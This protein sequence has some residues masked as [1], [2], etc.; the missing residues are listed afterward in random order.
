M[1]A[2]VNSWPLMEIEK[3]GI[4]LTTSR[5]IHKIHMAEYA[6][7]MMVIDARQLDQIL[8]NKTKKLWK[9][10]YLKDGISGKKL[11]IIGLG[12]IGQEI[13][14][15]ASLMGMEVYGIKR[16]VEVVP[17]VIEVYGNDKLDEIF[18]KSDYIINLL[19]HTKETD[20]IVDKKHMEMM[21]S[22][23]CLINMGRGGTTNEED[24]YEALNKRVFIMCISDV[25]AVEPLPQISPLWNLDNTII[26]P[27]I[28]G[29]NIHN[30][31]QAY[32][33]IKQNILSYTNAKS[34]LVNVYSHKLGY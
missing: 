3:R 8:L 33:I 19:P 30:M 4:I 20:K 18:R 22:S 31:D 9:Q 29:P 21:K 25:F 15:K 32:E 11:G 28:C 16:T 7:S 17:H 10:D 5:G 13:A 34:K 6:I 26:T 24:L 1:Q 2:G 12:S 23:A 27:H 14:K